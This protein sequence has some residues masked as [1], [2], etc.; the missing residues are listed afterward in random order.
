MTRTLAGN[1]LI[2]QSENGNTTK[3]IEEKKGNIWLIQ[4]QGSL[5]NDCAYDIADELFALISVNE[6]FVL[7]MNDTTYV[8]STFAELMVQ[9]QIRMEKTEFDTMPIKNMPK[10][11]FQAL[12][13]LGCIY[14]LDYELKET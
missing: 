3:M 8:S 6:G 12:K 1:A 4:L 10:N 7:D 13:E 9:L 14:S 2:F 11:V 5:G